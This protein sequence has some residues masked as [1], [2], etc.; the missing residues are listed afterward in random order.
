MVFFSD[1]GGEFT[2]HSVAHY[3][4]GL[5]ARHLFSPPQSPYTNGVNERH[6]GIMQ[7]WLSRVQVGAPTATVGDILAEA[8]FVK[9][10]TTRRHG[11]SAIF[12]AF[13]HEPQERFSTRI[14]DLVEPGPNIPELM[15]SRIAARAAARAA[16]LDL[17]TKDKLKDALERCIQQ[18][19]KT[20]L[21]P[22]TAVDYL[23]IPDQKTKMQYWEQD[24]VVVADGIEGSSSKMVVVRGANGHVQELAR[25]RLRKHHI[26]NLL[27]LS[28]IDI[29]ETCKRTPEIKEILQV[30]KPQPSTIP[31][32]ADVEQIQEHAAEQNGVEGAQVPQPVEPVADVLLAMTHTFFRCQASTPCS[33]VHCSLCAQWAP[34]WSGARWTTRREFI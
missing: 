31:Q 24:G 28:A 21:K 14:H 30:E 33:V 11:F 29:K 17:G 18:T 2:H 20:P 19:D 5:G 12:L 4:H 3:L 27:Q 32:Q 6:N 7:V 34:C 23:V 13:G 25:Q 15:R 26:P 10:M 22:G 8:E 16:V 1:Q 9:N